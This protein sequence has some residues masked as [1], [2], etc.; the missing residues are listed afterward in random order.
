MDLTN[1]TSFTLKFASF[2]NGDYGQMA[3]VEMS[4]DAGATWT[5]IYTCSPGASWTDVEVDLSAYSGASGLASVW[6]AFHADDAGQWASGWAIDDVE[7]SSG[8]LNFTKYGVFLDGAYVG[9]TPPTQRTWTYD[10]TTINYGQTYVAG[11]AALYCSGWSDLDTYTFTA[12]FLYPPRNLQATENQSAV[13]LTWQAPLSGDYAVSGSIP[14]TEMPNPNAEYSPMVTQRTGS[15]NTDAVWDVLLT[16]P[17]T[18]SGKA[19]VATDG[20]FIYTTIWS[21]G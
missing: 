21:G 18:S 17:T 8:G 7:V 11:V 20:N 3:Y 6:F 12:R 14:R 15:D 10:P 2:Y 4:T 1:A 5:P 19:G 13:I 16:F 9:W